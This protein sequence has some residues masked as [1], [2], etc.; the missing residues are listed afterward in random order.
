MSRCQCSLATVHSIDGKQ[1]AVLTPFDGVSH[2]WLSASGD[3]VVYKNSYAFISSN[4]LWILEA[5]EGGRVVDLGEPDSYA[6]TP[7]GSRLAV[8]ISN[9]NFGNIRTST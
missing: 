4:H 6:L 1:T 2:V 7:D 8:N 3:F 9:G 5:R